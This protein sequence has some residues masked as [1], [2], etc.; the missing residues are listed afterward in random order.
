MI[1]NLVVTFDLFCDLLC[2]FVRSFQ[3]I[4]NDFNRIQL[5]MHVHAVCIL[6]TYVHL[7]GFFK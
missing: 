2:I 1:Q 6:V 5:Y 4:Q 3:N 7:E